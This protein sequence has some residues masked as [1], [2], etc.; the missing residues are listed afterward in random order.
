MVAL[1]PARRTAPS[2]PGASRE[3]TCPCEPAGGDHD[4]HDSRRP[5]ALSRDARSLTRR[6]A[7]SLR[8]SGWSV[9]H[10]WLMELF[11]TRGHEL[12]H[13]GSAAD[14]S[15]P[16]RHP[17]TPTHTGRAPSSDPRW[18][19]GGVRRWLLWRNPTVE[20]APVPQD[21][22]TRFAELRV[23]ERYRDSLAPGSAERAG[24]EEV[25]RRAREA[26]ERVRLR[27]SA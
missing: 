16:T 23:A 25:V 7:G 22:S 2:L 26:Y 9:Q 12:R 15:N 3:C 11:A 19:R 14:D 21:P 4:A 20:M 24:A 1:P 6:P 10:P 5:R 18:S 8:A 13:R 27:P 17:R